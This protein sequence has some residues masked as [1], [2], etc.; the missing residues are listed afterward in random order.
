[1]SRKPLGYAAGPGVLLMY[2]TL[3]LSLFP[4]LLY[5]AGYEN[6]AADLSALIVVGVMVLVCFVP[7]CLICFSKKRNY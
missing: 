4:V 1:M 2:G 5:Q 7:L 3:S 6:T